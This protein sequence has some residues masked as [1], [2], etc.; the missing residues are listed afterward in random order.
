MLSYHLEKCT[1]NK[2][3]STEM[4]VFGA[5]SLAKGIPAITAASSNVDVL[6]STQIGITLRNRNKTCGY[7][8]CYRDPTTHKGIH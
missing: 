2:I 6:D 4:K 7:S 5:K 8:L 3:Q 1:E